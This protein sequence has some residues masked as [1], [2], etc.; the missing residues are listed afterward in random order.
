MIH[1]IIS[2]R[3]SFPV[4]FALLVA[5]LVS[6]ASLA[7]PAFSQNAASLSCQPMQV[8]RVTADVDDSARITLRGNVHRF[9]Q[10]RYD[11]GRVDD[12]LLMEHIIMML[13]RT[14]DQEHALNTRIDQMHNGRSSYYH[15]W[16][17]PEDVGGCYGVADSDI[18]AVTGWLERQ[19]FTIDAVPA[20][21]MLIIFTGTAGLM[22]E[23][24]NTEIHNLNVRGEK[25]IANMSEP[26][27]PKAL[28]PVIAGFR[29][30][31]NFYPKPL[32]HVL[33]PVER[34]SESG[35]WRPQ[36][37]NGAGVNKMLPMNHGATPM[38][39]LGNYFY[40][41]V[42]PQDLYTIY[43]ENPLL[44]ASTPINGAGQTLA[45][46]QDSDVNP[47]D[48][49]SFRS[50]FGLP[51]YP[52]TPNDT[53]GGVNYM[54]GISANNYC[55]DPGIVNGGEGEADI[56]VEWV[57]AT[58]P[59]ATIDFVS[60]ADTAT[61]FGGD[62]SAPYIIN[63]LASTVSAFSL[64]F[65]WCEANMSEVGLSA[66][67][68]YV[69]EWQQAVAQG[70]TPVV[71]SGDSGDNTC[72]RGNQLGPPDGSGGY[73][74]LSVSGLSVNGISSTPY[75]VAA[76]GT[77]FSD[78]YQTNYNPTAYW[79]KNDTTPYGS[80][81]SYIPETA[82]N[83][84][85]G[86]SVVVDYFNYAYGNSLSDEGLC[87]N[88]MFWAWTTLNGDSGGISTV[89]T[90]PTWQSA[91]GVGL[92]TNYTSTSFRNQPDI[93]LFASD[94]GGTWA[95]F[96]LFCKSDNAPCDYS[97]ENDASDMAAGGTSFVAPMV[98]GL[99]GLI[100]QAW[101]SGNPA[102]PTRQGQANY[103]LYA[104]ATAEYGTPGTPNISTAAPSTYTCEGSNLNAISSYGSIFPSCIFNEINRTSKHGTS[105]CLAGNTAGCLVSSNDEP[106]AT[107]SPN[108]YTSKSGD[109]YGLLSMSATTFEPAFPTSAGY[110]DA[111]GLGSV[112]IAN[113][114]N[115]WTKVTQQFASTTTAAANPT[116]L[117]NSVATTTLIATV[118]A[119]G[120]GGIAPPL[121]TVS[122]YTGGACTG[123]A[124]GTANLVPAASCTTSCN[125]AAT[126]SSVTG[127]Q[128]GIG[129]QSVV[130]CFS[131]DGANDAPSTSSAISIT[132]NGLTSTTELTISA[133]TVVVGSAAPITLTAT[134]A[135]GSGSGMPT[136]TITFSNGTTQLGQPVTLSN[137]TATYSYNTSSL[138]AGTYPLTAAYSG[139][140][141]YGPSTSS[142]GTLTVLPLIPTTSTE[143]IT[144]T[145]SSSES[146][147]G[148]SV[149]LA[150]TVAH[151]SGT[152]APTGTVTFANGSTALGSGTLNSIGTATYSTSSLAVGTYSIVASYGGDANYAASTSPAATFNVVDF[153]VAGNPTTITVSAPG[154]T[155]QTTLTITPK[156]GFNET[157]TYTCSGLPVQS[158]CT[159][160]SASST[161][162][163]LTI[164]T[165]APSARLDQDPLGRNSKLI[166]AL[167]LPG[168]LG[169][170]L[171]GG[172]RKKMRWGLFVL[173][174]ALTL[175]ILGLTAC[176]G[177][178]KSTT[179][180][181]KT[182]TPTGTSQV[183]VTAATSGTG[184]LSHTVQITLAVQ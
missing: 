135:P 15:Q 133:A 172:M 145:P 106:C 9:A 67:S 5:G 19:G 161:T 11:Q 56:D 57:G 126:L 146:N 4:R 120:R 10:A 55:G 23:A 1:R 168:F 3:S 59:A 140:T 88:S 24:F 71:S 184:A 111:T 129:T 60:C 181:T 125:S 63:N 180:T 104:L 115:N 144:G 98:T 109:A 143:S 119:T 90:L 69:T 87:N 30:L 28:A 18:A 152:A 84:T 7:R 26:Q 142:A 170:T 169:L 48:V 91:Y 138:A 97:N 101:P 117:A 174:L 43:N 68:F 39:T 52:T 27:I 44:T 79:S 65:G 58:A 178:S 20:G 94:G 89:S 22:R 61:T 17:R 62:L 45:I 103:T 128:I 182:G 74:A 116:T 118:T 137:G 121:G 86:N 157:L 159:F 95:H 163:T 160:A 16:L 75:N 134:V 96:L 32:S 54:F 50:Q 148:S 31:H 70:Q 36:S 114:V 100:N 2:L 38:V 179:T 37:A 107:G 112:N 155:G 25:H 141:N 72:D 99:I 123:T 49:T 108:C 12:S 110:N 92:N 127:A 53:Q 33:G 124:L 113:L 83:N 14:P 93:S 147:V 81:L 85:C 47:A 29:S 154:G 165:T 8:A 77:D 176:G 136:G 175:S 156:S 131:G 149:T 82:W 162:E 171:M 21:K 173:T 34:D 158:T 76:G 132:V 130:A 6:V 183:T 102:Q 78:S 164:Q 153:T 51:A 40:W 35:K 73:G 66:P 46:V 177:S 80:A 167:L 105:T 139:D 150:A 42:G 41:A 166:Y 122:F 64:S 13:K 151:S